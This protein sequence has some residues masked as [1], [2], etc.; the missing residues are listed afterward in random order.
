MSVELLIPREAKGAGSK[1][2]GFHDCFSFFFLFSLFSLPNYVSAFL[3]AGTA[4]LLS[5][6][7]TKMYFQCD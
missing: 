6:K 7:G 4:V 1:P 3:T 2:G 5:A